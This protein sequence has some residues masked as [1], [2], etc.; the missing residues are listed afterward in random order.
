MLGLAA[1][2]GFIFGLA[3]WMERFEPIGRI[4]DAVRESGIDAGAFYYTDVDE[5]AHAE[6]F[7][8]NS[9]GR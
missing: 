6:R 3:P 4:C 8:R 7:L 1:I 2:G 5:C 9:L